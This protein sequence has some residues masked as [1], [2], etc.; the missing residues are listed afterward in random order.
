MEEQLE[1]QG[2]LGMDYEIEEPLPSSDVCPTSQN[3]SVITHICADTH[4][5][6]AG[7]TQSIPL[8]PSG[9]GGTYHG[10]QVFS[11]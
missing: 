1:E 9:D 7:T 4:G 5:A 3:L 6:M 8:Y 10:N 2:D 11:V